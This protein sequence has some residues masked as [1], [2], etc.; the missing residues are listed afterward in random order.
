VLRLSPAPRT[1]LVVGAHADDIEIGCG[2]TIL[3]LVQD[4]P[5][6]QVRWVVLSGIGEREMEARKSAEAFLAGAAT[7]TVDVHGFRD[8]F[9]PSLHA[10]VKEVFEGLKDVRPDLILTHHRDDLHQDHRIVAELTW[11]TFRDHLVLGYEIPKYDGDLGRTNVYVP[12]TEE[13]AVRKVDLLAK[14]FPSQATRSW[15]D[16]DLFLSL[17][18]LRGMEAKAESNFAEG[19]YGPKVVL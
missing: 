16:R 14:H 1:L 15:F 17:M 4:H 12:V 3:R 8:G 18:R 11:N 19:F 2:A 6:L 13:L 7:A 9:F 5:Q 10:E